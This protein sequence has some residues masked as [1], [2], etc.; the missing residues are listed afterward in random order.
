VFITGSI[1]HRPTYWPNTYVKSFQKHSYPLCCWELETWQF[2]HIYRRQDLVYNTSYILLPLCLAFSPC[3]PHL[4]IPQKWYKF[5]SPVLHKHFISIMSHQ[6]NFVHLNLH[7]DRDANE[8]LASSTLSVLSHDH[9]PWHSIPFSTCTDKGFK[10]IHS[11]MGYASAVG[12]PVWR[13][14]SS[15]DHGEETC[16]VSATPYSVRDGTQWPMHRIRATVT[17]HCDY[18]SLKLCFMYPTLRNFY[19]N[20]FT[21][22]PKTQG[23]WQIYPSVCLQL[24]MTFNHLIADVC[25][26]TYCKQDI[27]ISSF[28]R[29]PFCVHFLVNLQNQQ[30][31]QSV[32]QPPNTRPEI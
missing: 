12:C 29:T 18:D 22:M 8:L 10:H 32:F 20:L 17:A 6:C 1:P 15:F 19:P 27:D 13:I 21:D 4:I 9:N 14:F 31:T 5:G 3:K 28:S 30:W 25:I 23:H 11:N 26:I 7:K 16:Q 2:E 24:I